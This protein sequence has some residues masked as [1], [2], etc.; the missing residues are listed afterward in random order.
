MN[1]EHC[2]LDTVQLDFL[3]Q[4][5]LWSQVVW[6]LLDHSQRRASLH[7]RDL[8]TNLKMHKIPIISVGL[9]PSF[10]FKD[11]KKEPR[12]E[13][14]KLYFKGCIS[15]MKLFFFLIVKYIF[16]VTNQQSHFH[17]VATYQL[18]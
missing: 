12:S 9:P 14:Q 13:I 11:N 17:E 7:C 1:S 8:G 16:T 6:G 4:N 18:L 5:K 3:R 2:D 10:L 15:G